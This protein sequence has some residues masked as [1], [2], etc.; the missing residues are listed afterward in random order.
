MEQRKHRRFRAQFR[1]AFSQNG[2]EVSGDGLVEDLSP[3]G[4]RIMSLN[5]VPLGAELDLQIFPDDSSP[6]LL[7]EKAT[8]RWSRGH[9]FGVAFPTT[10]SET[11][12]QL[13]QVWTM[14]GTDV[15]LR[16]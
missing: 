2:S 6:E 5:E 14:L 15:P 1:S 8:V 3:G 11:L 9:T 10:Q 12:M 4:Y 13:I 16:Q 7:L